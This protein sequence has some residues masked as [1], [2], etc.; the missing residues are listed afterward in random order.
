MPKCDSNVTAMLQQCNSNVAVI[1]SY[2]CLTVFAWRRV[3]LRF[4]D[5]KQL[6]WVSCILWCYYP[7]CYSI[8][9]WK[10]QFVV[11]HCHISTY[12]TIEEQEKKKGAAGHFDSSTFL[13]LKLLLREHLS[14][15]TGQFPDA[16]LLVGGSKK[17]RDFPL[18]I[19]IDF[20]QDTN[21]GDSRKRKWGR[22]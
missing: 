7:K 16:F 11:L 8:I 6:L 12:L 4:F 10:R 15:V 1:F 14:K 17:T 18:E 20:T 21:Y 19:W 9:F 22:F 5:P 13:L 2:S 3:V